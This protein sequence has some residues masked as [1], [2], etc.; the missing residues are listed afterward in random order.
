MIIHQLAKRLQNYLDE[1]RSKGQKISFVPTMGALH[2]G[3]ISLIK[4]AIASSDMV[5]CSIFVNPTQF[6]DPKDFSKYPITLGNDLEM[7]YEAGVAAVFVPSVEE[8][9]PNGPNIENSF[10]LNGLDKRIEGKYRPG[11]FQGVCQVVNRLLEIVQPGAIFMGQKDYQQCMVIRKML[12]VKDIPT[13]LEICPTI[14]ENSG[15]AMS[16]RNSRLSVPQRERAALIYK[17]L[18]AIRAGVSSGKYSELKNEA[19]A[20]LVREG[21]IVDYVEI[22]NAMDLSEV[23]DGEV[24]I[25]LV[26]LAAVFIG[27]VRLIDNLVLR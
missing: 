14:R 17:V 1:Q 13:Q 6:N 11:H 19:V 20:T 27:D 10:E 24:E 26:A 16:S 4:A 5:V 2:E 23:K 7:L 12:E 9:Y 25:P 21:F 8:I 22:V 15:L 3:H 18:S